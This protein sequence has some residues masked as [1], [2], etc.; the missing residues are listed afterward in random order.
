V[1]ACAMGRGAIL[2]RQ[3][4]AVK[5]F[6]AIG[7]GQCGTISQPPKDDVSDDLQVF[8][9]ARA[10]IF[11]PYISQRLGTVAAEVAWLGGGAHHRKPEWQD[12]T[13][14]MVAGRRKQS[15]FSIN[16]SCET[17]QPSN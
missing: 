6:A 4:G 17:L 9:Q 5:G 1:P 15:F 7:R 13:I 3:G 11:P 12:Y 8:W 10:V 14:R 16:H 2:G